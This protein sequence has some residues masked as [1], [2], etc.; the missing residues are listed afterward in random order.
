MPLGDV[1][2]KRLFFNRA[3]L[4][5]VRDRL[6][7]SSDDASCCLQSSPSSNS[8]PES[9]GSEVER[10]LPCRHVTAKL[11]SVLSQLS[12]SGVCVARTLSPDRSRN[13]G[14]SPWAGCLCVALCPGRVSSSELSSL[15]LDSL[16]EIV[17]T[18]CALFAAP[19][20]TS[21]RSAAYAF[22]TGNLSSGLELLQRCSPK[23]GGECCCSLPLV[24]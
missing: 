4:S 8:D 12:S 3:G 10:V 24:C 16:S 14:L 17:M 13:P 20:Q 19:R 1:C 7:L 23:S 6:S 21:A 15:E 2:D 5:L 22:P 18:L 11:S 9:L